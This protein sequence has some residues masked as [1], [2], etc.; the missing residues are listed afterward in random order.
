MSYDLERLQGD[1]A[2]IQHDDAGFGSGRLVAQDLIL[3]AAHT[4]WNGAAGTGPFLKEWQVRLARDY[5]A[6]KWP[7]RRGN[8]VVWYD[9]G[10]DL[11][12]IRLAGSEAGPARP[13]LRLRVATVSRNN[14]H[15]V[16]ARGYPRAS[17]Q[18]EGPRELTPA[19]GRIAGGQQDRPLDFGVDAC[20]LPNDP[21]AGWPGISGS[22]VLLRDGCHPDEIWIYGVVRAVPEN[23]NRKLTVARLAEA[24]RIP[25]FRQ[26][27]VA[28]GAP[29]QDADDP[30]LDE[31]GRANAGIRVL[32]DL[33]RDVPAAAEA[34][35]RCKEAIENTYRQVDKLDLLKT[36]HDALHTVELG[37]PADG[38]GGW[39]ARRAPVLR[40]HVSGKETRH[41]G[42]DEGARDAR[43]IARG[44]G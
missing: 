39:R 41:P 12:L 23:F 6:V 27:V 16:E 11:A 10:I 33:V 14:L 43:H 32:A 26:L 4:L 8:E 38:G 42:G 1:I 9:Q 3:T 22:T 36:V 13:A 25:A 29:D 21:H 7:F 17:K 20:D 5:N 2:Q 31:I 35:S 34:A 30:S 15:S 28:A 19:F 24:W 18:A 44:A 37:P 40:N